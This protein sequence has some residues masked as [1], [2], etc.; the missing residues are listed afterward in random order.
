MEEEKGA[1][2]RRLHPQSGRRKLTREEDEEEE[3]SEYMILKSSK[4][5][6]QACEQEEG[7]IANPAVVMGFLQMCNGGR[8]E[9][10]EMGNRESS[11][12]CQMFK[13]V[14]VF[15]MRKLHI[16]RWGEQRVLKEEM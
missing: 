16:C 7:R 10:E 12:S 2:K 8:K 9:K 1:R 6:S 15:R 5:V 11:R 13:C 3:T 4:K 14:F